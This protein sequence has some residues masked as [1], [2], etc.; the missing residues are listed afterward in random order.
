MESEWDDIDIVAKIWY[1]N[2]CEDVHLN[3]GKRRTYQ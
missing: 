2:N 1:Y 3:Y